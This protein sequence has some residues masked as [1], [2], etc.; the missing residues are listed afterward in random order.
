MAIGTPTER[1]QAAVTGQAVTPLV[2]APASTVVAGSVA[3]LFLTA[4]GNKQVTSVTDAVGNTWTVDHVA[5]DTTRAISVASC[6]VATQITSANNITINL[7]NTNNVTV[8]YWI[9]EVT[10]LATS[11][12]FDTSHDGSG[13]GTAPSSGATATLAQAD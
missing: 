3:I 10:G 7:S 8:D 12:V 11:S 1:K 2:V 6:Q 9:Q 13:S 5:T 4:G